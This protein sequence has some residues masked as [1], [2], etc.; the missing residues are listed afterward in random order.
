MWSTSAIPD[1]AVVLGDIASMEIHDL[2][3]LKPRC[4]LGE[5]VDAGNAVVLDPDTLTHARRAGFS[6]C[7]Y[8]VGSFQATGAD[9]LPPPAPQGILPNP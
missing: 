2:G 5:I 7:P 4:R 8:C 3:N 6:G 1:D 9:D